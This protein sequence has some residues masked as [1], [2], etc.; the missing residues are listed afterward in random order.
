LILQRYL[1]REIIGSTTAVSFLL[2]LIFL[3]SR[4]VK[5]LA[6]AASGKIDPTILFA[7][8]LYRV[9]SFLELILP[10]GLFISLML[11]FGR[12]YLD[13]E[14]R[15]LFA[16]GISRAQ[17][18]RKTMVPVL[19]V[20]LVVAVN[21]LYVT[22]RGLS[23][24][25]QMLSAQD[26]RSELDSLK[27]GRFQSFRRGGGVVYVEEVLSKENK[28]NRVFLFQD[29][30]GEQD[31]YGVLVS[32]QAQV[33]NLPEGRFL[34]M[35]EGYRLR[36]FE[37]DS[38]YQKVD[39]SE[40]GQRVSERNAE[41]LEKLKIEALPSLELLSSKNSEHQ[42]VLQWRLSLILLVPV[43]SLIAV[44]LSKTDPRQGRYSKIFP[45][46]LLYLLYLVSLNLLKDAMV[47]GEM[48]IVFAMWWIHALFLI[49]GAV[50][51]NWESLQSYFL[52]RK[53]DR[54]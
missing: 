25:Q 14:I 7:L 46:I 19:L 34:V 12:L 52:R 27:A 32:S 26:Q 48:P 45:A 9:P 41:K 29:I 44:S 51:F 10:L 4:F 18:L 17:L 42:S 20:A 16:S 40:Y 39:F 31:G 30:S 36:Q 49:V 54:T 28:M 21:S 3:S 2:L 23:E 6:D 35:E 15:V 11:V 53:D 8:I 50:L 24:V 38:T 13:N 37:G 22:P 33:K 47:K 43:V 5:Y 1:I